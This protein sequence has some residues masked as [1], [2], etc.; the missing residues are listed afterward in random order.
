MSLNGFLPTETNRKSMTAGMDLRFLPGATDFMADILAGGRTLRFRAAGQS[1]R[2]M[3]QSGDFVFLRKPDI[4]TLRMGD[5]LL[6][7]QA[8]GRMVLHRLIIVSR[9]KNGDIRRL[10]TKGDSVDIFDPPVGVEAV[11]GRVIAIERHRKRRMVR[12][13]D[14]TVF[15]GLNLMMAVYQ[16]IRSDIICACIRAGSG[17]RSRQD[18]D[19]AG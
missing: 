2:P 3:I 13:I 11:L 4:D 7:R 9:D 10:T 16:R 5:L 17:R 14:T 6:C 8:G 19:H 1:M 12:R 15:A 18:N